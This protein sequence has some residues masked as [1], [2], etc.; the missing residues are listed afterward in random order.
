MLRSI[1]IISFILTFVAHATDLN[2]I[3]EVG[4]ATEIELVKGEE[5]FIGERKIQVHKPIGKVR[6]SPKFLVD[7][8]FFLVQP[9]LS[10]TQLTSVRKHVLVMQFLI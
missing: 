4:T 6:K 1:L 2:L 8:Q 10:K 5:E 9:V 7:S 3:S